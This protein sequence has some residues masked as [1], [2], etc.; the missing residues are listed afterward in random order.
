[1]RIKT[2][3]LKFALAGVSVFILFLGLILTFGWLHSYFVQELSAEKMVMYFSLYST[4]GLALVIIGFV[5]RLL[6]LIDRNEP[7]SEQALQLVGAIKK[8]IFAIFVV[9]WGVLPMV[10][11]VAA[12]ENAPGVMVIGLGI[13]V[14]PLVLG[15]FVAT[16]EKLLASVIQLKTENDLTV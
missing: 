10:Y 6:R 12:A 8:M 4:A 14:I 16:I 11:Q 1:M 2:T 9:L 5:Y 3:F 15:I 7:F 13:V